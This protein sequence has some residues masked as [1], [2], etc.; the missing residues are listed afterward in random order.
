MLGHGGGGG[1]THSRINYKA[2]KETP[3]ARSQHFFRKS[4]EHAQSH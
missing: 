4:T 1:G 3:N 2:L